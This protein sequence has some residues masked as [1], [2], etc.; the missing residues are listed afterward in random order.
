MKLLPEKRVPSK[1]SMTLGIMT[2]SSVSMPCKK[3][4]VHSFSRDL[5]I[6]R[7]QDFFIAVISDEMEFL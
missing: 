3:Q 4:K 5:L 6:C 1:A 7:L 2:L